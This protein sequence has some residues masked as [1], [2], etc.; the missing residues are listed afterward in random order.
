MIFE[1]MMI[2]INHLNCLKVEFEKLLK[3]SFEN[4]LVLLLGLILLIFSLKQ[5]TFTKWKFNRID[6]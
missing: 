3:L 4:G 2:I 6:T 5:E 1:Q